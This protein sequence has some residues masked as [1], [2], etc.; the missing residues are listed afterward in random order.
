MDFYRINQHMENLKPMMPKFKKN[1]DNLWM[2]ATPKPINIDKYKGAQIIHTIQDSTQTEIKLWVLFHLNICYFCY[3][4]TLFH[5]GVGHY[6]PREQIQSVISN[7][8]GSVKK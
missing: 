2:A 3:L 5:M 1:F 7:A 4:S 6:G 8:L